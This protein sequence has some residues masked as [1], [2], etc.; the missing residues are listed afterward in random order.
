MSRI[1]KKDI[2]INNTISINMEENIITI[3]GPKGEL[4]YKLPTQIKVEQTNNILKVSRNGNT[5]ISQELHGLHRTLINN[6][7][8]GVTQGFSKTL[9]IQGVGYRAQI[10]KNN[11]I[12]NIGYSHPVHIKPPSNIN[13]KVDN[14]TQITVYGINKETV[15]QIAA[16]IRDIRPPEP[17][18]GKGIRYEKEQVR[19][20]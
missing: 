18:K 17:Y 15:G 9:E 6:M 10:D 5:K 2:Y 20:K 11:L 12:L 7:I 14:N 13:I 4:S 3:N 16:Q 19:K 8:I 1:G